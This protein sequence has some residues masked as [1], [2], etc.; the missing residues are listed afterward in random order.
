MKFMDRQYKLVKVPGKCSTDLLK[1]KLQHR[2]HLDKEPDVPVLVEC[3][4]KGEKDLLTVSAMLA[5]IRFE[6][7]LLV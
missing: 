4:T 3:W 1:V 6:H 5:L 7:E 2:F